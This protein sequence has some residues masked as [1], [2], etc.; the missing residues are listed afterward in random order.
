MVWIVRLRGC[1]LINNSRL[2]IATW[3][4]YQMLRLLRP[5]RRYCWAGFQTIRARVRSATNDHSARGQSLLL[6]LCIQYPWR[7][8]G[9]LVRWKISRVCS[10][11]VDIIAGHDNYRFLIRCDL[12]SFDY[13]GRTYT[14][15]LLILCVIKHCCQWGVLS[16]VCLRH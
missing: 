4:R 14:T 13:H 8:I 16:A 1:V 9:L 10:I 11:R 5:Q 7:S 2:S 3:C 6:I 12:R 15:A